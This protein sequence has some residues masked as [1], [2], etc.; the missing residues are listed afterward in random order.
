MITCR[1]EHL[2]YVHFL[3]REPTYLHIFLYNLIRHTPKLKKDFRFPN[4]GLCLVKKLA[5]LFFGVEDSR[6]FMA[7]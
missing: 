4:L 1:N 3:E 7:L 2:E 6:V 5:M